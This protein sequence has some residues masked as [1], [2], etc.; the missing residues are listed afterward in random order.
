MARRILTDE[1]I[2]KYSAGEI[3]RQK[4]SEILGR[5][6][7]ELSGL[8]AKR[9]VKIWDTKSKKTDEIEFLCELYKSKKLTRNQLVQKFGLTFLSLTCSIRNRG[10]PLWDAK[11]KRGNIVKRKPS[12]YY[13][14][15]EY[16]SHIMFTQTYI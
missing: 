5:T 6:E 15:R 12:R 16:K 11:R 14:W 3:D 13:D 1:L 7:T 8:F 10:I 2:N 4:L 9:G